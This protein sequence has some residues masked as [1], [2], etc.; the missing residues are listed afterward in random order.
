MN[1]FVF[2]FAGV[3]STLAAA[4]AWQALREMPRQ[5]SAGENKL[6]MSIQGHATPTVIFDTFGFV[7]L[8]IWN[9][10]QPGVA[11][12]ARTVSFDHGGHWG[13]EPGSRPR[14]AHQLALELRAALR[15]AGVAP[16]FVLVG[17]SMGG[18]YARVFTGMF[19]AE[20]AGILLVDPSMEEFM[21][22]FAR[23][24]P[25]IARISDENR[26]AQDE[27][28]SQWFSVAQARTSALP[29]IPI[30]LITATKPQDIL[31]RKVLPYW[32]RTHRD[33]LRSYPHAQHIVTTNSGHEVILSDPPLVIE[34]TRAMVEKVRSEQRAL[35]R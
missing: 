12:F 14:D 24:Y 26:R 3:V 33:W 21:E 32:L 7:N 2:I 19:P 34:A 20:V 8:E 16:P 18:I 30:T 13:S 11:R 1:R 17:Y 9:R 22:T 28:A 23:K 4:L 5:V 29:A 6:R 25:Q 35:G 10:V 27:W 15:Q 31:T